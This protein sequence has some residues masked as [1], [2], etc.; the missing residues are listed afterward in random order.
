MVPSASKSKLEGKFNI[1]RTE[2]NLHA[3]CYKNN[4][5]IHVEKRGCFTTKR[6]EAKKKIT[7]NAQKHLQV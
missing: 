4:D 2:A 7:N 3:F 6:P 5:T 1:R